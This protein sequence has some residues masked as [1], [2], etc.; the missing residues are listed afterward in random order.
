MSACERVT[1]LGFYITT[2]AT[3]WTQ[4]DNQP[5]PLHATKFGQHCDKFKGY[6]ADQNDRLKIHSISTQFL[7]CHSQMPCPPPHD[8]SSLCGRSCHTCKCRQPSAS[9][10]NHGFAYKAC[11]RSMLIP[12]TLCPT[13]MWRTAS[14]ALLC[15]SWTATT[16]VQ[17]VGGSNPC[18]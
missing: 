5:R 13:P 15:L 16:H 11:L 2:T 1:Y 14:P 7:L 10:C 6:V 8:P 9:S 4:Q 18:R 3:P 17:G 12:K